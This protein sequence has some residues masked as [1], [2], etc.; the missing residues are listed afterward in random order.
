M[1][2]LISP[3]FEQGVDFYIPIGAIFV[4]IKDCSNNTGEGRN[5]AAR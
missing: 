1:T 4:E 2:L 3:K 5:I